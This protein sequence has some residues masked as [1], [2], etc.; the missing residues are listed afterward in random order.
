MGIP[1]TVVAVTP[2][3]NGPPPNHPDMAAPPLPPSPH[4]LYIE[5]TSCHLICSR[6]VLGS[7]LVLPTIYG[8]F[9]SQTSELAWIFQ[10]YF[11]TDK[12]IEL[13]WELLVQL[14]MWCLPKFNMRNLRVHA[15][16]QPCHCMSTCLSLLNGTVNINTSSKIHSLI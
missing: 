16:G 14:S 13:P 7:C 8:R 5:S 9:L 11:L 6:Y 3:I 15:K 1:F 2:V 4:F 10:S 12:G